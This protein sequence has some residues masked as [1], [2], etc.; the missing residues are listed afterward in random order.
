MS[1]FFF[2]K[3]GFYNPKTLNNKAQSLFFFSDYKIRTAPKHR[4]SREKQSGLYNMNCIS[5]NYESVCS[6]DNQFKNNINLQNSHPYDLSHCSC[7]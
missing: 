5:T 7:S 6:M 2:H 1:F 4:F 3:F